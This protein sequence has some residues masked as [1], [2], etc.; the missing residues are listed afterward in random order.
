MSATSNLSSD[1]H[2]PGGAEDA[3]RRAHTRKRR[4]ILTGQWQSLVIDHM[5]EHFHKLRQWIIGK[6]DLSTNTLRS[7]VRQVSAL[8]DTEPIVRGDESVDEGCLGL[9]LN[10]VR[11]GGWWQLGTRHQ[12]WVEGMRESFVRPTWTP[13]RGFM[14]RLV[15]PDM[16]YAEAHPD[17]PDQPEYMVEARSRI[18]NGKLA[19]TWDVVDLRE[20]G[21]PTFK[22]VQPIQR[23]RGWQELDITEQVLGRDLSGPNYPWRLQDE[24]PVMP[25]VLY[26]AARTDRLFDALEGRELVEGTLTIAVLWTWWLHCVR[27]SSWVQR[28]TKD[29]S[30]KGSEEGAKGLP[31]ITHAFAV[32]DPQTLLQMRSD[33]GQGGGE[34]GQ[35]APPV[36]PATLGRAIA[37]FEIR[38]GA[39]FNLGPQDFQRSGPAESGYAISLK[40]S[41][42]REA[43]RRAEPQFRRGDEFLLRLCAVLL[44]RGGAPGG[45]FP[46]E[47]LSIEYPGLPM[48]PQEVMA[49]TEELAKLHPLGLVSPVDA[50]LALHPG[51]TREAAMDAL[52]EVSTENRVL[53][54][55]PGGM[56]NPSAL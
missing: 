12:Q 30:L 15:T 25:Y 5:A 20:E 40:R 41:A 17:D 50:Y 9:M 32:T 11:M 35:W 52:Q 48:S 42:V 34:I 56:T 6:P 16:V 38:L 1:P 44:N 10:A 39:H 46:E 45:P 7:V 55:A 31:E 2:L 21:S 8:Y 14:F 3:D 28:Y 13:D 54:V 33:D 19:W 22:V 18:I 43:Q 23:G 26:H 49:R 37:D 53:G 29:V 4:R 27:D 36:D 24:T 47:G 51:A